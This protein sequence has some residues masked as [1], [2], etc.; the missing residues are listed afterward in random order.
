MQ[1]KAP[2]ST[3]PADDVDRIREIIFGTHMQEYEKR[4]RAAGRDIEKMRKDLESRMSSTQSKL[5]ARLDQIDK[6][7]DEAL[8]HLSATVEQ[9]VAEM[10][11]MVAAEQAKLEETAAKLQS[12]TKGRVEA[13]EGLGRELHEAIDREVSL[14]KEAKLSREELGSALLE[15]GAKLQSEDL[16]ALEHPVAK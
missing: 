4:F 6:R 2:D 7:F 14:L 13:L 9:R 5:D 12:V 15:L 16:E 3:K 10:K 11:D 1:E 8:K